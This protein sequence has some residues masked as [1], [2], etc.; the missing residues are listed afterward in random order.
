MKRVFAIDI[1]ML[2]ALGDTTT[3]LLVDAMHAMR[4]ID[5]VL[6]MPCNSDLYSL[7]LSNS[8]E[9]YSNIS[10][11]EKALVDIRIDNYDA[12]E[13]SPYLTHQP[14]MTNP[15]F[16][17][18]VN[19]VIATQMCVMHN[20]MLNPDA[21]KFL[22]MS[23]RWTVDQPDIQTT[24][25]HKTN[26]HPVLVLDKTSLA[27]WLQARKPQYVSGRHFA[28]AYTQSRGVVS[29]F[30]AGGNV[31]YAQSLL[32]RAYVETESDVEY[33]QY[34]YT[35]DHLNARFVQFRSDNNAQYHGM[36]LADTDIRIPDY[37]HKKYHK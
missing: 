11:L 23:N 35:Y 26:C 21:D 25:D 8:A 16:D 10:I 4:D 29:T 36:D 12:S 37:L 27:Q 5:S 7:L 6:L 13:Y 28:T 18:S 9:D 30:L 15:A 24:K 1:P 17:T 32:D 19:E 33:P 34:L 3:D 14:V 22:L 2:V 31:A 20:R